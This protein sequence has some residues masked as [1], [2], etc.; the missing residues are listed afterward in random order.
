M[1]TAR[2]CTGGQ[3]AHVG[4]VPLCL[5]SRNSEDD[6][7]REGGERDAVHQRLMVLA[8]LGVRL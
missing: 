6:R 7:E 2:A 4:Q 3:S 1:T 8:L 5:L